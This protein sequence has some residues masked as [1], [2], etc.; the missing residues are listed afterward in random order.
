MKRKEEICN[1]VKKYY[2]DSNKESI[3]VLEGRFLDMFLNT[4]LSIEDIDKKIKKALEPRYKV[5]PKDN[6]YLTYI[7]VLAISMSVVICIF[8]LI[9]NAV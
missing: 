3:E 6:S 2:D 5:L 8:A 1:I 4:N 7:C 9:K